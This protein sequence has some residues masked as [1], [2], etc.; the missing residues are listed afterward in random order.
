VEV[1]VEVVVSGCPE[2]HKT[3]MT[4]TTGT[5]IKKVKPGLLGASVG[6]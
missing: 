1:A 5:T 6:M 4:T 2:D 3:M